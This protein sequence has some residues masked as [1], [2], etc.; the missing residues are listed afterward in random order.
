MSLL[1]MTIR[2]P[3]E[4]AELLD[5][6][7]GVLARWQ[8]PSC[9]LDVSAIDVLLR[10]DRWRRLYRGTY[11][12]H[13][14]QLTRESV[15]WA[16]VLRCGP[17]AAL[18][19]LTAACL[20]ELAV[21]RGGPVHVTV[22]DQKRMSFSPWEFSG[23]LPRIIV[24]HSVRLDERRHPVRVPPRMKIVETVVDLAD[25]AADR[26][27]MYSWLSRACSRGLVTPEQLRLAILR[28]RKLRHRG[29]LLSAV[30][31]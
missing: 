9:G 6:Q 3:P 13:T 27:A 31:D 12:T 15:L 28:R 18:S 23:G 16:A 14:G 22:P 2:T 21:D 4:C 29:D 10:Q 17:D 7:R 20:D 19:H 8:A 26:D 24:H 5:L 30:G 25:M 1:G 11:A